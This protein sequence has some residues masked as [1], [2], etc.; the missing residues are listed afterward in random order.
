MCGGCVPEVSLGLGVG[1]L[2]EGT[3]DL[4]FWGDEDRS[5]VLGRGPPLMT[6][7]MHGSACTNVRGGKGT[8]TS[9]FARMGV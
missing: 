6:V 2:C 4:K 3:W 1:E 8:T 7:L 5:R 9:P